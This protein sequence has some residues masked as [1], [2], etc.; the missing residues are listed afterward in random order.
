MEATLLDRF[1][2]L[3][4]LSE[5]ALWLLERSARPVTVPPGTRIFEAG[6]PC[7]NYVMV[8]SG[9]VRVQQVSESGREIVLYR[10]AG[11]ETCI[12]TTACLLAHEDYAAEAIAETEVSAVVVPRACFDQLLAES[13]RFRDFVFAAYASRLTDL[14][15]LVKEVAFGHVDERLA[16]R[17]L[18]LQ[19]PSGGLSV[20]HQ[21]LAVEL[22]TA[23]EVVSRQLK[24]F[25]RRG[26]IRRER[27]RI[28]ILDATALREL[29]RKA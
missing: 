3:R 2:A 17:L 20:T 16:E 21:D 10:V 23:R 25:E 9:R 15:L 14:L 1:P 18:D 28:D 12:L 22:G 27:G 4:Q 29:S 19:D 7:G 24:E 8:A 5:S 13:T 11:G 6:S 26:C